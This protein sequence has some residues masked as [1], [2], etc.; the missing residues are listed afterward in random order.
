MRVSNGL[1]CFWPHLLLFLFVEE[2]HHNGVYMMNNLVFGVGLA[3]T[4]KFVNVTRIEPGK[5]S[6]GV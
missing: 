6:D 3:L 5:E 2:V 4:A 1:I